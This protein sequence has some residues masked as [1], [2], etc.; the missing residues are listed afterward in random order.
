MNDEQ[1]IDEALIEFERT[2][3]SALANQHDKR[4]LEAMR[5][6]GEKLRALGVNPHAITPLDVDSARQR[7]RVREAVCIGNR[8]QEARCPIAKHAGK[9]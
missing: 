8:H 5:K 4:L 9:K 6:A 2:F 1:Q 7:V 3:K